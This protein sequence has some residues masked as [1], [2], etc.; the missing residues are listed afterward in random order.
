MKEIYC[1][2][3]ETPKKELCSHTTNPLQLRSLCKRCR[4]EDC[5]VWRH[6]PLRGNR[7]YER[8]DVSEEG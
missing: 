4:K 6:T 2:V 1:E 5:Q 8:L 3:N 7:P